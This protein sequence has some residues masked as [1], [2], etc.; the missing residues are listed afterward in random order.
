MELDSST[1]KG[2]FPLAQVQISVD[3][4]KNR[5]PEKMSTEIEDDAEPLLRR[6]CPAPPAL[7]LQMAAAGKSR[8][9][10]ICYG[11]GPSPLRNAAPPPMAEQTLHFDGGCRATEADLENP[12]SV[13]LSTVYYW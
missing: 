11:D 6:E 4:G 8:E 7:L 2:H 1:S 9:E 13:S 12:A 5:Y 3:A 10:Q